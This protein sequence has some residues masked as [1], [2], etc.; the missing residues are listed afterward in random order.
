MVTQLPCIAH[1][2]VLLKSSTMKYLV[3]SWRARRAVLCIRMSLFLELACNISLRRCWKGAFLIMRSVFF[4]NFRISLR[5]TVP[6]RQ[7]W[8]FLTAIVGFFAA[9]H[10]PLV[11]KCRHGDFSPVDLRAVCLV[12]AMVLYVYGCGCFFL[13]LHRSSH[14]YCVC[15]GNKETVWENRIISPIDRNVNGRKPLP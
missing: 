10:A 6:G 1:K 8:G 14:H 5:A 2:L 9:A 7:Q 15:S 12:W 11:A 13:S 4:W 3:A